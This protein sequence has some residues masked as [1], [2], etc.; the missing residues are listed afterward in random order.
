MLLD[1]AQA[2]AFDQLREEMQ[3]GTF[4]G[5]HEADINFPPTFK[6]DVLRTLKGS[7]SIQKNKHHRHKRRT[8]DLS[9]V[10]EQDDIEYQQNAE[11]EDD[12]IHSDDEDT[13]SVA[14]TVLTSSQ[15][16]RSKD[17]EGSKAEKR[18]SRIALS[19]LVLDTKL[20]NHAA[21]K[22]KQKWLSLLSPSTR[23]L[24]AGSHVEP[25]TTVQPATPLLPY[26]DSTSPTPSKE[27]PVTHSIS[28]VDLSTS[29]S[30]GVSSRPSFK[31]RRSTHS[32]GERPFTNHKVI[33]EKGVYDSSSKQRVPSW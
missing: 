22:A 20:F 5:F 28:A 31:R 19:P 18:R 32:L 3:K 29:G 13:A 16:H 33:E 9:G 21:H 1:Y 23:S 24:S 17:E 7:K 26:E 15:S 30:G 12:E 25:K 6:Y 10:L 11:E 2:L 8:H 27:S 14:S 4:A